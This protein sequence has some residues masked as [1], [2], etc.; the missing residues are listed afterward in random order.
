MS[1]RSSGSGRTSTSVTSVSEWD[2]EYD[3]WA[4]M[5]VFR[6][7]SN[8]AYSWGWKW[9]QN[10]LEKKLGYL[11]GV[12]FFRARCEAM[13]IVL[14]Q[15]PGGGFNGWWERQ[16]VRHKLGPRRVAPVDPGKVLRSE[17]GLQR[18]AR[19]HVSSRTRR[20]RRHVGVR[21]DPPVPP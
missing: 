3:E 5:Q 6:R 7:N 9:H 12:D 4:Q 1:T 16:Y 18:K 13:E 11:K 10:Q 19:A 8:D 15:F 17:R 14:S 2:Q 20:R 21:V